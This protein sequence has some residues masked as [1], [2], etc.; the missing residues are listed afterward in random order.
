MIKKKKKHFNF[1]I[2]MIVFGILIITILPMNLLYIHAARQS[3]KALNVQAETSVQNLLALIGTDISERITQTNRYMGEV[4]SNN[5][6]YTAL[7]QQESWDEYQLNKFFLGQ[8]LIDN[9]TV[10]T[11]ADTYFVFS[12]TKADY[13]IARPGRLANQLSYESLKNFITE[14]VSNNKASSWHL[15][16]IDEKPFLM[17]CHY[18]KETYFGGLI[19]LS[20]QKKILLKGLTYE[21]ARVFFEED[22]KG[23]SSGKEAAEVLPDK[24]IVCVSKQIPVCPKFFMVCEVSE[25]DV[26]QDLAFLQRYSYSIALGYLILI[27]VLLLVLGILLLNP[28]KILLAAIPEIGKGNTSYRIGNHHVAREYRQIYE[29]FDHTLDEMQELKIQNYE[30]ELEK[31]KAELET[32]QMAL[33][34]QQV[35]LQN[36]QLMIRPHFLQNTLGLLYSLSQMEETKSLGETIL[37]LSDYFRHIYRSEDLIPFSTELTLIE[38]Y[39]AMAEIQF[40]ESFEIDYQIDPELEEVKVPPLLI[41]NFIEN[42]ISHA[43]RKG[44][45][46][47]IELRLRREGDLAVFEIKDN[48]IG[49]PVG[50]LEEINQGHPIRDKK[51][52]HVGIYNSWKRLEILYG[53]KASLHYES[54]LFKGTT[55]TVKIPIPEEQQEEQ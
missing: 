31:Q 44:D 36:L 49:I 2:Q 45:Y 42:V 55:V 22:P 41:H 8:N 30:I 34:K 16:W 4:V 24:N 20:N 6:Y 37:Y 54:A 32:K 28:L 48:G 19:E 27:P 11:A 39:L 14:Y 9:T 46:L 47:M 15:I 29:T 3:V 51:R 1:S 21:S 53:G 10:S 35:E 26:I 43:S 7:P 18:A 13:L 33:E 17:C 52:M 40:P 50:K 25:A 12:K 38:G 23:R 5:A